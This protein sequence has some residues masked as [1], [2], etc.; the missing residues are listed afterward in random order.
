M[1]L[2]GVA[3]TIRPRTARAHAA[4]PASNVTVLRPRPRPYDHESETA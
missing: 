3:R 1:L 4:V 2:G